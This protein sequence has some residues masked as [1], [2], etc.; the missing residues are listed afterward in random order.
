MICHQQIPYWLTLFCCC[1]CCFFVFFKNYSEDINPFVKLLLPLFWTSGDVY[2]GFKASV[3]PL[4]CVFCHMYV[5]AYRFTY[6]ATPADLLVV[7]YYG[8]SEIYVTVWRTGTL[9]DWVIEAS[10]RS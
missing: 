8:R 2:P 5:M 3:D 4:T 1:Y 7:I 6:G 9:T 10:Q